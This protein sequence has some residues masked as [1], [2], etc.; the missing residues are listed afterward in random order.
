MFWFTLLSDN[1]A[2]AMSRVVAGVGE[3]DNNDMTV[4]KFG[5]KLVEKNDS[6]ILET[7]LGDKEYSEIFIKLVEEISMNLEQPAT[8][9]NA[10]VF[11][12]MLAD[13]DLAIANYI[14]GARLFS[15]GDLASAVNYLTKAEGQGFTPVYSLLGYANYT[16]FL[17]NKDSKHLNKALHY[18]KLSGNNKDFYGL[19]NLGVL[20]SVGNNKNMQD[21]KFY[22]NESVKGM[23]SDVGVISSPAEFNLKS[24]DMGVPLYVFLLNNTVGITLFDGEYTKEMINREVEAYLE[25]PELNK[26][27][28][29]IDITGKYPKSLAEHARYVF[30]KS[31]F[32]VK[33]T[34]P[35]TPT[36]AVPIT[37]ASAGSITD[38]PSL[39]H[40]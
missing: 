26:S 13:K 17:K 35:I 12:K 28:L 36:S 31:G 38:S 19:N 5:T 37:P 8:N 1:F 6:Q 10:D 15:K 39:T 20:Y 22:L 14:Y 9:D 3:K 30:T 40:Q 33:L 11:I 34:A 29:T 25:F 7:Y 27:S 32:E 18:L 4:V 21:A 2:T 24:V 23:A 16:Q